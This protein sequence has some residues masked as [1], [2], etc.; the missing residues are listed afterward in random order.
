MVGSKFVFFVGGLVDSTVG[1]NVGLQ[2][3]VGTA[4]GRLLGLRRFVTGDE[5]TGL[6]VGLGSA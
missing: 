1:C 6:L 2:V 3:D 4:L 5:D